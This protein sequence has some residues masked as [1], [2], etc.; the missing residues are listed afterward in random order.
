MDNLCANILKYCQLNPEGYCS[1]Y[2]D[3]I[4]W[5]KDNPKLS[6]EEWKTLAKIIY[7]DEIK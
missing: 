7:K 6:F 4:T 1:C 3:Y 2:L 5:S